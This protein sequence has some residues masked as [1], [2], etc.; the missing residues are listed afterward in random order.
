MIGS[1]T[2]VE[3]DYSA[4]NKKT[5]PVTQSL[6]GLSISSNYFNSS[7]SADPDTLI[8]VPQCCFWLRKD[9]I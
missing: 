3:T 1:R 4:H 7:L 9:L 5:S 6:A 8:P 2:R